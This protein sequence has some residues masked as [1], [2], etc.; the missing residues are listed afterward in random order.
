MQVFWGT[1]RTDG[2]QVGTHQTTF[3]PSATT[4]D[5]FVDGGANSPGG[6]VYTGNHPYYIGR[7]DLPASYGYQSSQNSAGSVSGCTVNPVDTPGAAT[8][9]Q[10]A[11]FETAFVC[12]N[13]QSTGKDKLLESFSWGFT[14]LGTTFQATPTLAAGGSYVTHNSPTAKF[15]DTLSADYPGYSHT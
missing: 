3:P 8:L 7:A 4:Y 1:R 14:G 13:H 12:L 10:D 5:S 9:H 11:Y 2:V 6:A 15:E